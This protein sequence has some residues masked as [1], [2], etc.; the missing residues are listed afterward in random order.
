MPKVTPRSAMDSLFPSI[1]N[2]IFAAILL[3]FGS[4]VEK[5][6]TF[7]TDMGRIIFGEKPSEYYSFRVKIQTTR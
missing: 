7:K 3:V 1:L 6:T 2:E 4:E 5:G